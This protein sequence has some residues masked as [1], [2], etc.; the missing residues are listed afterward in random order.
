[1]REIV[2][3]ETDVEELAEKEPRQLPDSFAVM[4]TIAA[5]SESAVAS[6]EFRFFFGGASGPSGVRLLGRFCHADPLLGE[7]VKAHLR[8]EEALRPDAIFAE[9]VHLPEGRVGNV[10]HRPLLRAFEIP[11]LGQPSVRREWQLPLDDLLVSVADGRILLRSARHGREVIPR[12]SNAHNF[13]SNSLG[14][15][16]FLCAL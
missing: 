7:R 1:S 2:L 5:A 12:L 9:V 10:L 4:G 3:D 15:Y 6:G 11:Y 16:R 13:S 14:V 8:Q